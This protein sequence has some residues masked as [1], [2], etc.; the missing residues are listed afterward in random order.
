MPGGMKMRSGVFIGG[1]IAAQGR[2]AGLAGA[3]MNP[4][5]AGFDAFFADF[6]TGFERWLQAGK[7]CAKGRVNHHQGE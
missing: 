6:P 4:A 2:A 7:M 1:A 3:Q 5:A